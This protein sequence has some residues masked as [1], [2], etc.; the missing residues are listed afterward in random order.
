MGVRDITQR[1]L[2]CLWFLSN[3]LT[4]PEIAKRLFISE[5]TVKTDFMMAAK[6]LGVRNRTAA[7]AFAIRKRLIK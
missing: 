5:R 3:G 2:R 6:H 4:T 7:V 1:Q